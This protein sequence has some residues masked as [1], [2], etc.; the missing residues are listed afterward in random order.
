MPLTPFV[1]RSSNLGVAVG[2]WT[3]VLLPQILGR[4]VPEV[5]PQNQKHSAAAPPVHKLGSSGVE[6][7]LG[8]MEETLAASKPVAGGSKK[9]A[10]FFAFFGWESGGRIC[11][12]VAMQVQCCCYLLF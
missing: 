5:A 2:A 8:Y 10:T 4:E 6:A 9:V 3:R 12:Y 11:I 7:A 1:G